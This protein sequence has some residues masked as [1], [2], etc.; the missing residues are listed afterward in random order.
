M[1]GTFRTSVDAARQQGDLTRKPGSSGPSIK[2]LNMLSAAGNMAIQRAAA[3]ASVANM[4]AIALDSGSCSC[5]G[6]CDNCKK[7]RL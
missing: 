7:K 4:G 2:P 5:G 6:S 1:T 3:S